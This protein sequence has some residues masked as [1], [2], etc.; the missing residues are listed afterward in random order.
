MPEDAGVMTVGDRRPSPLDEVL[1]G[2]R[3]IRRYARRAVPDALVLE[4]LDLAR[5]APSS[6]G[7]Q[8]WCFVVIR[9]R[10]TLERLA[11]IKDDYCAADK[12]AAYPAGF[13]AR[14]PLVVAV[15]V[16]RGRA[17]GRSRESGVLAASHL[18]LAAH[19]RGLGGTY[20]TGYQPDDP[21]LEHEIRLLLRL[22]ADVDPIALVPLG[23]PAERPTP[24]ELR[25]LEK[26]IHQETF[27]MPPQG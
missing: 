17:H 7:G 10:E 1:R 20:L 25:P 2:R 16:E 24:K 21:G 12:R 23:F 6:L 27:G 22:P 11:A 8:P 5:H 4:I 9:S 19:G 26:L 15:C 18:L 14:A 3:S 13:L